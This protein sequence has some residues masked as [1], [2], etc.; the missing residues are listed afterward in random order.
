VEEPQPVSAPRIPYASVEMAIAQSTFEKKTVLRGPEA[1]VGRVVNELEGANFIH[2]CCHATTR[3]NRPLESSILMAQDQSLTLRQLASINLRC[4]RLILLSACETGKIS[5]TLP[6]QLITLA[7]GLLGAGS[8][9]VIASGWDLEDASTSLILLR[10]Y[11]DWQTCGHPPIK[12]LS[13]AQCWMRDT[14]NREKVAFLQSLLPTFGGRELYDVEAVKQLYRFV[15]L[16]PPL[17]R[18]FEHPH[19]WAVLSY[20]GQ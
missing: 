10:F 15:V 4:A 2:F 12:A 5:R 14:T 17:E 19:Y 1:T 16:K 11:S 7:V 18:S 8:E 13:S 9:A 20:Y 6:D 3:F